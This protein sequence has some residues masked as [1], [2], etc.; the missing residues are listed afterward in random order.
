MGRGPG[1]S[2]DEQQQQEESGPWPGV[3]ADL[4]NRSRRQFLA[5][6]LATITGLFTTLGVAMQDMLRYFTPTDDQPTEEESPP[7]VDDTDQ[8]AV[9]TPPGEIFVQQFRDGYRATSPDGEVLESGSNGREILTAAIDTI[10][11]GGKLFVRGSYELDRAIEINKPVQLDGYDASINLTESAGTAFDIAGDERYTTELDDDAATGANTL[12][13]DS[14]ED[15]EQGD[16]ILL[17]DEGG[18]GVIGR[19]QP[20]GEPHTVLEVDG[21]TVLLE[22]TIVWRDG[23]ESG[24]LV[25]VVNPI[26]VSCRGFKLSAP[27]KDGSYIGIIARACRN[28]SFSELTLD[29]FGNRAIAV[30][31]AANSRIRDCTIRQ[32]ADIEASDGYGIQIR[33]G[34]HDIVVEGCTA[35]ECRH[36]LSVTPAGPRE[37]AS[38]SLIFRDC[39]VSAEGSAALNC[40]GG[41]AHDVRFEGCTIHTW[42]Q[43]GVRSGAQKTSVTG[44]EFRMSAHHAITTRNDGQEMVLTVTD[45]DIY[46]ASNAIQLNDD[47]SYEFEPSWKLV[48]LNGVRA[49]DCNQLFELKP[50][51]V[52][53]VRSLQ[54]TGCQWDRVAQEGIRLENQVDSGTIEGND[55]GNAPNQAHLSLRTSDD[56][57]IQNLQISGNRFQQSS[58][59]EPFM[60]LSDTSKCSISNNKFDAET[61]TQLCTE[62]GSTTHNI[63]KGNTYFGPGADSGLIDI[64]DG[65]VADANRFFDTDEEDWS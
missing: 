39:F 25:Y 12:E 45:T 64:D 20:A 10:P 48:Q 32:S 16:L 51:P 6:V 58:G 31:A 26:E 2:E 56:S 41:S 50:G 13:L 29:R 62:Q 37:V 55:F 22:D 65:S 57:T 30:E 46:G 23:Y 24:T 21:S 38:R 63:Y 36:P 52:D 7:G 61:P 4:D 42:D 14:T 54:I 59:S 1:N 35:K 40:H 11:D 5:V 53:R 17:E 47:S 9:S 33:A 27:A 8:D 60:R 49:T 19:G 28:S 34:C 44:C 18:P 15:I 43:P 3:L